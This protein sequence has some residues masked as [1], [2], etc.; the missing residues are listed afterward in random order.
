MNPPNLEPDDELPVL[1]LTR[2]ARRRLFG[3]AFTLVSLLALPYLIPPLSA[4]R[5]WRPDAGYTPFW[6]ITARPSIQ[7]QERE[8]QQL[9]D[10]EKIAVAAEARGP[11]EPPSREAPAELEPG[12]A[13]PPGRPAQRALP[14]ERPEQRALP[15]VRQPPVS[16]RH[17]FPAY[18][19]HP[20]D[21]DKV[22]TLIENPEALAHYLGRLTLT[23]LK[24]PGAITR[25]GHWGDSVL[26]GDGL[27]HA[28]RKRLQD[29]FG[30]S[31]HGFHALSRYS[32][33]YLHRGVRFQDR[34]GWRSCEIIFHCRPDEHYGYGGVHSS[35]AGGA[36]SL[37]QTA[38]DGPG[39]RVSRFE[40]WYARSRDGGRFD[41]KI[42]GELAKVID[43]RS[44]GPS[45]EVEVFD[46]PD[47]PHS[48]ELRA[49]GGGTSR[50]Y[51]VVL[52][53]DAPGVVWDE[54]S[55]IGSFTQR[56][57]YQNS[58]H[59]GWQLRRRGIDLM[60]FIF[61]GN[62]VQREFD[63][64]KSE[65]RPYEEEYTRVLRKFRRGRP[66]ASCMVMSLIDHGVRS[67]GGVRTRGIVPRLV[68]SQRRVATREGCAFFDT[69]HAMGGANSIARWLRARPQLAAPDYSH[70][71]LAGQGVIAT[72]LYRA[73][74]H[75]YAA[76]R[77]KNVGAP[78]P[79]IGSDGSGADDGRAD[80]TSAYGSPAP[81]IAADAGPPEP[82]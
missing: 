1:L 43:T 41:V 26:G 45:D 18:P 58:E 81:P 12:F 75:E 23:D 59:L 51:G 22:E 38:K 52:E 11:L 44:D 40:L 20:D 64:L 50:G 57:D 78:L 53:R 27:T 70:P 71:T 37:W 65:M 24:V 4:I 46:V 10:F 28:L 61:G 74:M 8:Q 5:P 66:E 63:D 16:A 36:Q 68:A 80:D 33:G 82:R 17:V 13:L 47:G 6:N 25:A 56:L 31:G 9:A 60:V 55:L 54:L 2:A 14:P 48:F 77:R 72:L 7:Q 42:D 32:I 21:D 30:D 67:E 3:A 39:D 62:D 15:A 76:Y 19:G 73:L 35:S 34:G 49:A 29:R 69:F 79:E